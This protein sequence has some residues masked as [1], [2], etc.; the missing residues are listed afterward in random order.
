MDE[1]K[2]GLANEEA[3]LVLQVALKHR[4]QIDEV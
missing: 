1:I 3:G 2:D 4:V